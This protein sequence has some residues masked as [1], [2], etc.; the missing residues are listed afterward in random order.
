MHI[1]AKPLS[2]RLIKSSNESRISMCA[3]FSHCERPKVD[4]LI[5]MRE[6]SN[7][8]RTYDEIEMRFQP[9]SNVQVDTAVPLQ[10]FE[11]KNA[12]PYEK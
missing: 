6:E 5:K 11:L 8:Y 4:V 10:V 3:K 9:L 7:K 12:R 1:N 2:N